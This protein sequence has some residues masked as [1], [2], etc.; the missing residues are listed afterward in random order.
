MFFF[1][2][3]ISFSKANTTL[4]E[5]HLANLSS[6]LRSLAGMILLQFGQHISSKDLEL[7]NSGLFKSKK[8]S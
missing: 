4:Q 6:I 8:S 1:K 3:A 7:D 2:E 5:E